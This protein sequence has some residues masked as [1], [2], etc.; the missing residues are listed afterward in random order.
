[1]AQFY[2]LREAAEILRMSPEKLKEMAKSS[3]LRAFQDRGNIHFRK[4]EIAEMARSLGLG[5]DTELP[6]E[7]LSQKPPSKPPSSG[8]SP[9]PGKS[10]PS[11]KSPPPTGKSAAPS[12]RRTM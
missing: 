5:S 9:P 4:E 3:K 11:S 2:T 7:A 12:S 8:K 6:M 1:M 10:P